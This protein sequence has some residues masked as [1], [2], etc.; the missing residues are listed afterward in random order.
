MPREMYWFTALLCHRIDG[1]MK[2]WNNSKHKRLL[3]ETSIEDYYNTNDLHSL[4]IH[5]QMIFLEIERH[6]ISI[7]SWFELLVYW[8]RKLT[9][10]LVVVWKPLVDFILF[11]LKFNDDKEPLLFESTFLSIFFLKM[12]LN[13]SKVF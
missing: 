3:I 11:N 13:L 8:L 1:G 9:N 5:L 2:E 7:H 4:I 6:S 10:D 12:H